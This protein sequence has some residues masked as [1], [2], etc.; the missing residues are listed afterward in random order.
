M[1]LLPTADFGRILDFFEFHSQKNDKV[2]EHY[3][4]CNIN[5]DSE[6]I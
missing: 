4:I 1:P 2:P 5:A 3:Q 6:L